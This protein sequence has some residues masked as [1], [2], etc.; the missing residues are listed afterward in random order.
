[1]P[2][3]AESPTRSPVKLPGPVVTAMRSSAAK[4]MAASLITRAISG[5]RASAWPRFMASDS[6]AINLPA[7]VSRMPAAQ[8]SS[9]VSMA[10]ISM[11]ELYSSFVGWA[12]P[13]GRA[14]ARPMTGSA[15]PPSRRAEQRA[16]REERLCPPTGE[17]S[18]RPN[19]DHVGHKVPEQVLDAVLQRRG[20]G[21]AAGARTLHVQIDDAVLETAES[22]VA[23]VIGDR[24]AHARFDQVLDGR[25]RLG[26]IVAEELVLFVG[27]L[28]AC[29]RPVG[30]QRSAG[31]VVLHDGA[32]DR[33]L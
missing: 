26:V 11:R 16:R 6:C 2:R 30:Q 25:D 28:V 14:N 9:A 13:T 33:G 22:D 7:S 1:M 18:H 20:G 5:I 17:K 10:R 32:E 27:G 29:N 23:A 21:W 15:C 31:H 3:A 19:F 24:R 4:A 8:A 12:K